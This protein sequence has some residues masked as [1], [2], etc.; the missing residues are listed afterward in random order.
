MPASRTGDGGNRTGPA[1]HARRVRAWS[2]SAPRYSATST[3]ARRAR[4]RGHKHSL[5]Y[6]K[7]ASPAARRPP[8]SSP[9]RPLCRTG[10]RGRPAPREHFSW[11]STARGHPGKM[12]PWPAGALLARQHP[13]LASPAGP[14]GARGGRQQA[15]LGQGWCLGCKR[16]RRSACCCVDGTRALTRG[17]RPYAPCHDRHTRG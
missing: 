3:T 6:K 4:T 15:T 11:V 17:I 8:C 7:R 10:H 5:S 2:A 1:S 14:Y 12:F 9:A 16:R 13:H